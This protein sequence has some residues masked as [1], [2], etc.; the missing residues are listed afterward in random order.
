ME[1]VPLASS[2]IAVSAGLRLI[3]TPK[4]S[5]DAAFHARLAPPLNDHAAQLSL[6][7]FVF[8]WMQRPWRRQ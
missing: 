4:L 3:L 7:C 1:G 2:A 5:L 6:S 8:D